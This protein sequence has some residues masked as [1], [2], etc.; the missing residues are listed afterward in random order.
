VADAQRWG[1]RELINAGSR[2]GADLR[3]DRDN[4]RRR[5]VLWPL[6]PVLGNVLDG[7]EASVPEETADAAWEALALQALWRVSCAGVRS[8]PPRAAGPVPWGVRPRG[9]LRAATGVDTDLFVN[10]LLI[11]FTAAF[12][13]QGLAHWPIPIRELGFF[14]SFCRL[15][16]QSGAPSVRWLQGLA[17]EFAAQARA[18]S[19]DGVDLRV[20]RAPRDRREPL[21]RVPASHDA[22]AQ[23][24]GE[25]NP[26]N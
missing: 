3:H 4:R 19:S 18:K 26:A 10:D 16:R 5:N 9:A 17:G 20:A 14:A 6:L 7:D 8:V 15:Y 22:G 11:R 12:T 2:N 23:W 25:H 1:V 13:D 21:R 24:V